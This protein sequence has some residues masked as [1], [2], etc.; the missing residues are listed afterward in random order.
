MKLKCPKLSAAMLCA[1]MPFAAAACGDDDDESLRTEQGV[2]IEDL[3]QAGAIDDDEFGIYET[4]ELESFGDTSLLGRT[5]VVSAEIDRM[6]EEDAAFVMGEDVEGGV[7]V[8]TPPRLQDEPALAEGVAVQVVGRVVEFDLVQIE[9]AYNPFD[10]DD[11]LY[12]DWED[13]VALIAQAVSFAPIEAF[14]QGAQGASLRPLNGSGAIG[15]V[16]VEEQGDGIEVTLTTVGV[17][18]DLP[19]PQH[20]HIGG[21]GLCPDSR[22]DTGDD[23]VLDTVEGQKAYG[24]IKV[25]LTTTGDVSPDSALA[26]D[27]FPTAAA[28]RTY[29]Y[30][31][32]L[33]LP[34]GVTY[35][36]VRKGVVV[37]HGY[38]RLADDESKYDGAEKSPL[39]QSLPLEATLPVLCGQ[40]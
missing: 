24:P 28:D 3:A 23:T 8:I 21:M 6:I 37:V 7:L 29:T 19:H 35:E 11:D 22:T 39:D 20:I 4:D 33:D 14:D 30:H 36:D 26:V 2:D 12:V 25:S 18:A 40:L 38:S 16:A 9:E 17:S 13:R 15:T 31:R 32:T 34:T 10:L 27:R 1:L 5:V